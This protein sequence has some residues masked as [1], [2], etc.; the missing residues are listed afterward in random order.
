MPCPP[1]VSGGQ[2]VQV[3]SQASLGNQ[4]KTSDK[5]TNSPRPNFC[6]IFSFYVI[7][8]SPG[9][10]FLAPAPTLPACPGTGQTRAEGRGRRGPT[11][12]ALVHLQFEGTSGN[13]S[14]SR[15]GSWHVCL[16]MGATASAHVW[17]ATGRL[18]LRRLHSSKLDESSDKAGAKDAPS[19]ICGRWCGV[20]SRVPG[21]AEAWPQE[22]SNLLC[23]A[24]GPTLDRKLCPLSTQPPERGEGPNGAGPTGT[25]GQRPPALCTVTAL[26]FERRL[27]T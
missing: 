14:Q 22:I 7:L 15:H 24:H 13:R 23:S 3:P 2:G 19:C 21:V 18:A 20:F 27:E 8:R 9:M 5:K 16:G 17:P 12:Q 6:Q 11:G 10:L 25:S 4:L 1:L 26:L